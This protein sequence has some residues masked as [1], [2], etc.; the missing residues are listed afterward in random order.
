M[1]NT[2]TS[3]FGAVRAEPSRTVLSRVASLLDV[4]E[5]A[6]GGLSVTELG[7]LTQLPKSTAFRLAEQMVDLGWLER[8]PAGY[9]VGV[10]MLE[11]GGLARR[12]TRLR[13]RAM[14]YLSELAAATGLAV[15]FA[16]LD[17]D[18]V[19]IVEQIP[20]RGCDLPLTG[21]CRFPAATTSLGKVLLA[22]GGN[23]Q[24]D[25]VQRA[26][27]LAAVR[28]RQIAFDADGTYAG[29]SCIGAPVR[30]SGRA[31]AAVSVSAPSA[32][33]RPNSVAP[34]LA[35]TVDS[36]WSALFDRNR[37]TVSA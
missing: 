19:V 24:L 16:V 13:N 25:G 1:Q 3:E 8:D 20:M 7:R 11:L 9:R 22:F 10:R 30:N 35:N 29:I 15:N 31:I 26:P 32:A 17:G 2:L 12:R 33:L 21:R 27:E 28:R 14:P 37:L 18:E 5:G 34:V 6:D 36:I 23:D 4:F